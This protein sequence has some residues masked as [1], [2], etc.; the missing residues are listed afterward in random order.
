L[1]ERKEGSFHEPQTILIAYNIESEI[2]LE[3]RKNV[4]IVQFNKFIV[5]MGCIRKW[6]IEKSLF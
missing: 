6:G 1:V 3:A 5:Q 4:L 2:L